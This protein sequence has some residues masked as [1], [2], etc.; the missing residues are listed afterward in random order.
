MNI[1][2]SSKKIEN[3][4]ITQARIQVVDVDNMASGVEVAA[5]ALEEA[6]LP[7]QRVVWV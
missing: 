4:K 7:C 1:F 6:A 3:K 5:V 2:H